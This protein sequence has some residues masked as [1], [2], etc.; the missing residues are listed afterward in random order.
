MS[1]IMIIAN[2]L[3]AKVRI[4]CLV[5]TCCL[6]DMYVVETNSQVEQVMSEIEMAVEYEELE[7]CP[8]VFSSLDEVLDHYQE[9][10]SPVRLEFHK[11]RLADT[12]KNVRR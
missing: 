10:F 8:E 5:T 1:D 7:S 9:L 11:Q 4:G 6:E 3:R 2:S 12:L